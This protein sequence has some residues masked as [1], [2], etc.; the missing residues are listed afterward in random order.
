MIHKHS[1]EKTLHLLSRI[2][3]S[4]F[5]NILAN[6]VTD[7]WSAKNLHTLEIEGSP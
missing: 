3:S 6:S 4:N 5:T 1:L 2:E 7:T